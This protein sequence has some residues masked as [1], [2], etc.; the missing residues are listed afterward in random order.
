MNKISRENKSG[1]NMHKEE[2][3]GVRRKFQGGGS[4]GES[5]L[6]QGW[7]T[8]G[9]TGEVVPRIRMKQED[10]HGEY[11]KIEKLRQREQ[12]IQKP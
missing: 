11:M 1:G 4:E 10:K 7:L 5:W 3:Q 6:F 12:Q 2:K 9:L 8:E